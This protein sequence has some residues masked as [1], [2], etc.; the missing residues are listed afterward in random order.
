MRAA[1]RDRDIG[2]VYRMLGDAGISQRQIAE[3]TGQAQSEVSAV[4]N[5]RQVIVYDVLKRIADGLGIP[6]GYLGLAYTASGQDG[7]Y[8]GDDPPSGDTEEVDDDMLRRDVL[9]KGSIALVGVPVLGKLL[10][11]SAGPGELDLPSQVGLADVAEIA[12]TTEQLRVAA[13]TRGGQARA[14]SAAAVQ[15]GRLTQ[16]P[17]NE[18]VT[19]RL[20]TQLA[21][22]NE[23]AGWCCFDSDLDR[24][25][26]LHYRK[27]VDLAQ[28]ARDNYRVASAIR[29]MGIIDGARGNLD[30]AMK[31]FDMA[32]LI[33]GQ[34][35][36]PELISWL[37]AVS[38]N[39]LALMGHDNAL[40]ELAKAQGGWRPSNDFERADTAYQTALVHMDLGN[41][42]AAERFAS[43]VNGGGWHRP[44]GVFASVL[45]ATIYV[46]AGEPRG[47]LM[48]KSAIDAVAPLHS[49]RARER[50]QPLVTALE[51]RPRSDHRDLARAA[52][53]ITAGRSGNN[54][55]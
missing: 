42:E 32:H 49:V 10:A 9:A 48:A 55:V 4:C 36:D 40:R 6:C 27:A 51:A 19:A 1:L 26:R 16:V 12:N 37:H 22:L 46:Q 33:V 3:R 38:A 44:V 5:G 50:L 2:A 54:N 17:A 29:F 18:A 34:K 23:L 15:Y 45:R 39:S 43:T 52:R 7:S 13:R 11:S 20:L 8:D 35:G 53:R 41:L 14:V 28:Q 21:D 24:P 31:Q 47:A 25:A 30:D